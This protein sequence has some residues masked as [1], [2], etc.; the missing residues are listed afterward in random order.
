LIAEYEYILTG[1]ASKKW[2]ASSFTIAGF[3]QSC[4]LDDEFVFNVDG[5]YEYHA[6]EETCGDTS[7]DNYKTGNWQV[8]ADGSSLTF[9]KGTDYE[10]TANIV[11]AN[12][13][14]LELKG[15]YYLLPIRG[16]YIN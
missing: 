8:D 12:N 7:N 6:G 13:G 5:T 16:K 2:S 1:W 15:F 9:D 11:M 14:S 4:R 10:Y 3:T